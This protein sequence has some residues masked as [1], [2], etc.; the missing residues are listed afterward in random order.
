VVKDK[1]TV[2][3]GGLIG[4][5]TEDNTYKLPLLGDIPLLGWLFKSK[6]KSREKTNLYVFITPHIV[7]TQKEASAIYQEKR[8]TMGTVV[9][10]IIKLDDKSRWIMFRPVRPNLPK[11]Q[12]R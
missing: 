8:E 12:C 7:R 10:G 2:V 1:E 9:E 5:S 6:G 4:D 3:I 11:I